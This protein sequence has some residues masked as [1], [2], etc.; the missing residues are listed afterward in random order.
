[1]LI[2]KLKLLYLANLLILNLLYINIKQIYKFEL[3]D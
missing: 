3:V 2:N 1:M